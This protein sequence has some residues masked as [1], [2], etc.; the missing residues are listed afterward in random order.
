M[1]SSRFPNKF[2]STVVSPNGIQMVW[3]IVTTLWGFT[4]GLSLFFMDDIYL[5]SLSLEQYPHPSVQQ[6]GK[7]LSAWIEDNPDIQQVSR[8]KNELTTPVETF[9]ER[10][11]RFGTRAL[12]EQR[13]RTSPVQ[14]IEVPSVVPALPTKQEPLTK[15]K[16]VVVPYPRKVLMMGG[17]SMKTA[18]GSLLQS[19]FREQGVESIREA[20]IGTGLARADVVDWVSKANTIMDVHSDIDLLIVQFIGNDCQTIVS[21]EHEIIA[22][23]GSDEW[24][25]SYV[26]RWEA[27]YQSAKAHNVQ[28]VIVGLP[29]M[30]SNRFD[31]KVTTVSE[32]VFEWAKQYDI[33][34]IPVRSLTVDAEGRYKQYL[35]IDKKPV[36]IRLKDG[37]HLSYQGSKII[38]RHIFNRLQARFQWAKETTSKADEQ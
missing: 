22:R 1:F 18:M 6:L 10:E 16:P 5:Y 25:D 12:T 7:S 34:I 8:V 11:M 13:T 9:Y 21:P 24:T 33:P 38:S 14:A 23:Y 35:T 31:A 26:E 15:P 19:L 36:K 20:Q 4:L 27:L 29:I 30:K 3:P 2:S 17:S 32:T 37:V 28:M